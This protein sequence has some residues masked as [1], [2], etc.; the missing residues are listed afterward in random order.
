MCVFVRI[1]VGTLRCN[2]VFH[3][4]CQSIL[5]CD[6]YCQMNTCGTDKSCRFSIVYDGVIFIFDAVVN[7]S[8]TCLRA[9]V[10]SSVCL[11]AIP[12]AEKEEGFSRDSR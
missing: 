11:C 9:S 10:Y 1:C 4:C 7:K 3:I 8:F 6:S 2:I 12:P 5:H